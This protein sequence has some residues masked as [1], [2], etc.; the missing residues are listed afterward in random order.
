MAA[1]GC[2]ERS[3]SYSVGCFPRL[4]GRYGVGIVDVLPS[5][6]GEEPLL[7]RLYY[8]TQRDAGDV[9]QS[10][11]AKGMAKEYRRA[12]FKSIISGLKAVDIGTI[13]SIDKSKT[14]GELLRKYM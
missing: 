13:P 2:S 8:P 4:S 14:N 9:P 3:N 7:M 12:Y 1:A 5:L 11:L 6:R 10:I